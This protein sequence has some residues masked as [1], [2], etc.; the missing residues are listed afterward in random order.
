MCRS[1]DSKMFIQKLTDGT[2]QIGGSNADLSNLVAGLQ[3]AIENP[4]VAIESQLLNE[5]GVARL[6]IQADA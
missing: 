5:D 6:L 2:V 3:L 1:R 4:G